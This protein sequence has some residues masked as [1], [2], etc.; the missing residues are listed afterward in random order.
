MDPDTETTT[1]TTTGVYRLPV[2]QYMRPDGR[3]EQNWI[4]VPEQLGALATAVLDDP[5]TR[6]FAAEV[7]MTGT[8]SFTLELADRDEP[9]P[10][11]ILTPNGPEVITAVE[12]LIRQAHAWVT[13]EES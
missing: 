12:K 4:D 8:V 5:R 10:V 1:E 3:Q 13:T 2:T 6:R 9:D 11:N 7:L